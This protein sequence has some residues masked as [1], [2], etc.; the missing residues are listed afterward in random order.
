MGLRQG[1]CAR[2]LEPLGVLV[3]HRVD[4]VDEGFV[5]GEEAVAA[6]EQIA[7]EPAL[8]QVFSEHFHD[9]AVGGEIFIDRQDSRIPASCR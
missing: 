5:A 7:F 2:D 1:D 9:A 8:A 4:D 3:D 6:G